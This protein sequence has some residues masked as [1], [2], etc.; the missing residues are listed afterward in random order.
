MSMGAELGQ[1]ILQT[2]NSK[3]SEDSVGDN[4]PSEYANECVQCRPNSTVDKTHYVVLSC[5][6]VVACLDCGA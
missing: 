4:P 1:Y 6:T 2:H 5:F 3:N